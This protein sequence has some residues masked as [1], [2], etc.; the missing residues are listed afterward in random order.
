MEITVYDNLKRVVLSLIVAVMV[1]VVGAFSTFFF[2]SKGN[3]AIPPE[4]Y[5]VLI[6]PVIMILALFAFIHMM[7]GARIRFERA[8]GEVVQCYFAFGREV[9]RKTF[10]MPD[11]DRVSLT[12]GFSRRLPGFTGRTS[13]RI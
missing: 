6:A 7:T 10:N 4:A 2:I 9:R 11:F 5:P 13:T 12:R 3:T 1:G 8:T